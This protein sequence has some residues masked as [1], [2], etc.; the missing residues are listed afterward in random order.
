ML[1]SDYWKKM[2][3]PLLIGQF[4]TFKR[5]TFSTIFQL[6]LIKRSPGVLAR[7]SNSPTVCCEC[8]R[9]CIVYD[10]SG[11]SSCGWEHKTEAAILTLGPCRDCVC[12]S[13]LH[14]LTVVLSTPTHP[15]FHTVSQWHTFVWVHTALVC[16]CPCSGSFLHLEC[17][18][19]L[20]LT[21]N[22]SVFFMIWFQEHFLHEV[23]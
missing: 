16:V 11:L 20:H 10:C 22:I 1:K 23:L 17:C 18:L 21:S 5:I 13:V 19:S 3:V 12:Q 8:I 2:P 15:C 4:E 7:G 14:T 9:W 6:G